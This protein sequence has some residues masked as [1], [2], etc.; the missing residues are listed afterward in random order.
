M[1]VT[2][3]TYQSN[4]SAFVRPG[5]PILASHFLWYRYSC[6][7]IEFRSTTM[8][9]MI[10]PGRWPLKISKLRLSC[11]RIKWTRYISK[12]YLTRHQQ[13]ERIFTAKMPIFGWSRSSMI[14]ILICISNEFLS[15]DQHTSK[16]VRLHP[17]DWLPSIYFFSSEK[18]P[19]YMSSILH[20][21]L[22]FKLRVTT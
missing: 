4:R 21:L 22:Q 15:P 3:N 20:S 2:R 14:C 9:H 1:N 6:Q 5:K 17:Q 12:F 11:E 16:V 10:L 13:I 18:M 19:Y 7:L 8:Q